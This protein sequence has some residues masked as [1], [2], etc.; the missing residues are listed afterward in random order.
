MA[1]LL[2][3]TACTHSVDRRLSSSNDSP[4]RH[5]VISVHGLSGDPSNFGFLGEALTSHLQG[6]RPNERTE[7]YS[8]SY[9]TGQKSTNS[10]YDFAYDYLGPFIQNQVF[11]IQD[12][13]PEDRITLIGHSQGGL[14]SM[15][16]YV[17]SLIPADPHRST[18]QSREYPVKFQKYAQQVDSI[19]T[20]GSPFWGS[21]LA[22]RF[23]DEL[24]PNLNEL[25]GLSNQFELESL[26]LGSNTVYRFRRT[27]IGL[28]QKNI[29][30]SALKA[31][32]VNLAGI[33]PE[34]DSSLF[35]SNPDGTTEASKWTRRIYRLIRSFLIKTPFGEERY[36]G[37]MAVL[38]PSAHLGFLYAQNLD[39][40]SDQEI[41]GSDFQF[42]NESPSSNFSTIAIEAAHSYV[43]SRYNISM[44]LVPKE[45]LK[46]ETCIHPSYQYI[47]QETASCGQGGCD[48]DVE[49]KFS[50]SFEKARPGQVVKD[51]QLQASVRGFLV[52]VNLRLPD[53]NYDIESSQYKK[54]PGM[55]FESPVP[56]PKIGD[57][58]AVK[59]VLNPKFFF[60]RAV[61]LNTDKDDYVMNMSPLARVRLGR[62]SEFLS[63]T[64]TLQVIVD[65]GSARKDL[66]FVVTGSVTPSEA[67]IRE[68]EAYR[69]LLQNGIDLPIQVS[70]PGLKP[71]S[72]YVRV[73]PGYSSF[74]DL[75]MAYR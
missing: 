14:V 74:L 10:I 32:F 47:L 24:K 8:V 57:E 33:Y 7:Y 22:S 58:M 23:S 16:W 71:R 56:E 37:D 11:G 65:K 18:E 73:R 46:I 64:A 6:L 9:P 29:Y 55:Y 62:K 13:R 63:K 2:L 45:C 53:L 25:L 12:I 43:D 21:Q 41:R 54:H 40:Q 27:S 36:E 51:Q 60:R 39:P 68:P 26:Q 28:S 5:I 67:G 15:I 52:E 38:Y 19:I 75:A 59:W 42:A 61:Q 48:P 70:L 30:G 3:V 17:D 1:V 44:A 35:N 69:R 49:Q 34:S 50:E 72:F 4:P 66:R 31:R 20:L